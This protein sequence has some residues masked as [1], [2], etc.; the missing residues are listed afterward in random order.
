[1]PHS[2][3]SPFGILLIIVTFLFV[4]KRIDMLTN[5]HREE[6]GIEYI[7]VTGLLH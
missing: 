6:C 7:D 2:Q 5:S 1:M 4:A 3:F